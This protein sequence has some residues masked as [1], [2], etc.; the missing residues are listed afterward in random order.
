M[1]I[2]SAWQPSSGRGTGGFVEKRGNGI[3]DA[4]GIGIPAAV[5][6][7]EKRP[8]LN[9]FHAMT[10]GFPLFKNYLFITTRNGIRVMEILLR[11]SKYFN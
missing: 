2:T 7:C 4:H 10:H 9:V 6:R 8:A 1:L 11:R 3:F 5:L